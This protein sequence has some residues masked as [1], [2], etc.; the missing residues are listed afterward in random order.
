MKTLRPLGHSDLLLSP[1][2]LG[3]WQFSNQGRNWWKPVSSYLVYDIIKASLQGGINWLDTAEYYGHGNSE[4]FIG[5]ILKLLEKEGSL[6]GT[7]YIADKW[8]PLLR[9]AKTIAQTFSGRLSN[10]QRPFIDLYQISSP[11]FHFLSQKTSRRISK[12]A[13]KRPYKSHW[14]QQL[15]GPSNGKNG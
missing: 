5:S 6:T 10:L 14:G 3:T 15:F 11:Y 7:I 2:G 4:K 9:S 1:I 13:R 12:L 8:F